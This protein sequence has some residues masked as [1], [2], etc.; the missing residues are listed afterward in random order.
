MKIKSFTVLPDTPKKLNPLSELANNM[1]F[2]WNHDVQELFEELD[3]E[4]WKVTHSNPSRMLC[5]LPQ[6]RLNEV[7]K[8]KVYVAK[9]E[10]V[11]ADFKSYMKADTWYSKKYKS[12]TSNEIVYFCCEY[13]IHESFPNY[14]GG[15]GILAGDHM[16]SAS[17]LGLP[18]IG[19]G[20]LY[21]KGY[22]HQSLNKEGRQQESYLD[23]DWLSIPV[24]LE[25]DENGEAHKVCIRIAGQ[26]VWFQIW[27]VNVGRIKIYMLDTNIDEN[28]LENRVITKMLYDPDR[29]IRV[30]QEYLLGIGGMMALEK[31]GL[32]PKIYHVNE[33]HAAFLLL[34]RTRKLM[35]DKSL[36]LKEAREV[37]WGSTVFT[38][39]TP[40]PAGNE[41]F[42]AYLLE[43]FFME[44]IPQL[45]IS[46]DEFLG[47]GRENPYNPDEEFCMTVLALRF[48]AYANGVAALHGVISRD[49]WKNLYPDIPVDEVPIGHVTN[50]VHARTWL[51]PKLLVMLEAHSPSQNIEE[52]NDEQIWNGVFHIS[53]KDFW[54]FKLKN[55]KRLIRFVRERVYKQM[56][57]RY[58]P[59]T[60][61]AEVQDIFNSNALTI[62]FA[63]RFATYK[64]AFLLFMDENRLREVL[65]NPECPVQI[66]IAGKAHPADEMGK[67]IIRR[68]YE[69]AQHPDF[70]KNLIILEDYD[71]EV[72]RQMVQG[73]DIWLNN[74]R[75]PMEASGTSGMKVSLNGSLNLSILDG[76]WDEAYTPDVGW[77]IGQGESYDD[78]HYQDRVESE[79]LIGTLL[80]EV[81]PTFF[82]RNEEGLPVEWIRKSKMSVSVLGKE[83]SSNRMVADYVEKFYS[84]A[85]KSE[86]LLVDADYNAAREL[87]AWRQKAEQNWHE[88]KVH[89]VITLDEEYISKGATVPI[90]AKVDVGQFD[91]GNIQVECYHGPL[92]PEKE[93]TETHREVMTLH[94]CEKE[95]CL[96]ESK[97]KVSIGGSY[98]FTVRVL[99]GHANLASPYLPGLITWAE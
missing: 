75:R 78:P 8:D 42:P 36:S 54:D 63:R 91:G 58:A 40:V 44:Y 3:P 68:I 16:K 69:L 7:A 38:T 93:F 5:E 73:V 10:K 25:K 64:R 84:K 20:L 85:L 90:E 2:S 55:R 21:Y 83:F 50:G 53:D 12:E 94:S 28:T 27:S 52:V 30:C 23:N 65:C 86:K 35:A 72:G 61:L 66:I 43:P 15:L 48:A 92:S 79:L 49:M 39:H 24:N 6:E 97:I 33:G 70:K 62:G 71:I 87:A 9:M 57:R 98:G 46:W 88:V 19:I 80:K 4:L 59:A 41:R 45:G 14:S 26:D 99:P 95:V 89:E 82:E 47:L 31:L 17:D 37:V 32:A 77:A 96:Y 34:E 74:P 22:F 76:W 60:E 51:D 81:I 13:G 67:D 56:Q 11:Y 1:Y 29:H 18:L